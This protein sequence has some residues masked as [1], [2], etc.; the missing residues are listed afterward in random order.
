M[1]ELFADERCSEAILESLRT[2]DVGRMVPPTRVDMESEASAAEPQCP[3][4]GCGC[5]PGTTGVVAGDLGRGLPG[6]LGWC[7]S[8]D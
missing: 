7:N 1:A 3:R 8:E 6:L 5:D 4:D 2:T